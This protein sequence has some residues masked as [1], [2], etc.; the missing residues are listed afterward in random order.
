[1]SVL[2]GATTNTSTRTQF[3]GRDCCRGLRIGRLEQT[4]PVSHAPC[5]AIAC[6]YSNT[7][8]GGE[9]GTVVKACTAA[10]PP[11]I[12]VFHG[13][14]FRKSS[15]SLQCSEG[16]PAMKQTTAVGCTR[17]EGETDCPEETYMSDH[18]K[19]STGVTPHRRQSCT[20]LHAGRQL[21]VAHR[22]SIHCI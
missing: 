14:W 22:L 19:S 15:N 8:Q 6:V 11:V 5:Q 12:A 17:A 13:K 16:L 3:R 1:M 21:A 20:P 7:S 18:L 9:A 10:Y 2:Q 4:T